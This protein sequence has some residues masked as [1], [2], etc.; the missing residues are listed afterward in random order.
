MCS[1]DLSDDFGGSWRDIS[2]GL[3]DRHGFPLAVHPREVNTAFVVPAYQ[4]KGCKKH[5]S[6]I[7]GA[8][9]VYRT[10][11][12]GRRGWEKL[13]QGLPKKVHC[14]VL[15]HGM[16]A[17]SLKPA[18]VYFATTTGEVY[19]SNTEGDSWTVLGKGLPRVQGVV[20]AVV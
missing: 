15:R 17:D 2:S 16:D 12:G 8:L 10:R 4:G 7:M 6:C 14:V 19:G 1:S 3:P 18:G 11:S 5:N 9:E 20:A 13:A